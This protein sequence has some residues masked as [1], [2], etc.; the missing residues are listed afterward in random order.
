MQETTFT[1]P[2]GKPFI[3]IAQRTAMTVVIV[4]ASL[5]LKIWR[6]SAPLQ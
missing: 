4:R 5:D 1:K 6:L 3:L 2:L